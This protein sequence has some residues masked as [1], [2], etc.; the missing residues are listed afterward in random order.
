M[1]QEVRAHPS[2]SAGAEEWQMFNISGFCSKE[3]ERRSA[4]STAIFFSIHSICFL[5]KSRLN[6]GAG[7][8]RNQ[9][10]GCSAALGGRMSPS[11]G[12]DLTREHISMGTSR[13]GAIAFARG[14]HQPWP[15]LSGGKHS[16]LAQQLQGLALPLSCSM[17][18]HSQAIHNVLW[19][20][21]PGPPQPRMQTRRWHKLPA[22]TLAPTASS[23]WLPSLP[24]AENY[25]LKYVFFLVLSLQHQYFKSCYSHHS[26]CSAPDPAKAIRRRK[27]QQPPTERICSL[28]K[29]TLGIIMPALCA[30]KS[31]VIAMVIIS[32]MWDF[33]RLK[34]NY[35]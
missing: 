15:H 34:Y 7:W 23:P 31:S 24:R 4:E 32:H 28:L 5:H 11:T 17:V 16:I 21:S 10:A 19:I 12:S 9:P 27:T 29:G 3:R 20:P 1:V 13:A 18:W 30:Q 35:S 14:T 8:N 26:G 25:F 33:F 2:K 6:S 22:R